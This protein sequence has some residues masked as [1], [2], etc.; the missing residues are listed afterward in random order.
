MSIAIAPQSNITFTITSMPKRDAHIKTIQRLMRMQLHI[1]KGLKHLAI[2]RRQKDN[3]TTIRAGRP[4]TNRKRVT[5]LTPV[6]LG[7]TFTLLITPQIMP[8]IKSV[9]KF[10]STKA[11]K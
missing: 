4:W 7:N 1:Q 9:E 11:A 3:V 10:L 8:D 2:R 6:E 5:K